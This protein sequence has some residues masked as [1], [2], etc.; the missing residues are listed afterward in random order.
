MTSVTAARGPGGHGRG[1]MKSDSQSATAQPD[2]TYS[3]QKPAIFSAVWMLYMLSKLSIPIAVVCLLAAA[4]YMG[5]VDF[6]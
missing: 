5:W 3:V 6:N 2:W 4:K 1:A